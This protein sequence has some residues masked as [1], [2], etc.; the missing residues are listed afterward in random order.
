[1]MSEPFA[2][3]RSP[4]ERK[5]TDDIG[6]LFGQPILRRCVKVERVGLALGEN[7]CTPQ[8]DVSLPYKVGRGNGKIDR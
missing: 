3:H 7:S 4:G 1:M 2:H 5:K 6:N 8:V